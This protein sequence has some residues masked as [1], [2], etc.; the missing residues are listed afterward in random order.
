[1]LLPAFLLLLTTALPAFSQPASQTSTAALDQG[2]RIEREIS[3]GEMHSYTLNVPAGGYAHVDVDQIGISVGISVFADGQKLRGVDASGGGVHEVFSLVAE[4]ATTYR[5][6][7]LA[8]D[9]AAEP[10]KYVIVVDDAHTAT[11]AN[12]AHLEGEKLFE[13]GMDLLYQQTKEARTEAIQKFQQS[14][15]FWQTAKNQSGEARAYYMMGHIYNLL[16]EFAKAEE[17]ATKGLPIAKAAGDKSVE[18][19]LLD[20]IGMSYNERGLRK[21]ALEFYLQAL[22]LRTATDRVGRANTL[23]NIGI[24]YA[25]MSERPKALEYLNEASTILSELGD[26]NW[27]ALCLELTGLMEAKSTLMKSQSL[28]ARHRTPCQQVWLWC[29]KIESARG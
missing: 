6:E 2:K 23:N 8:P 11:E 17:T 14:I 21:K 4:R 9:K 29:L 16:G 20:T 26:R 25:W 19:Y 22:P 12:K 18:A 7:V 15:A 3:G 13:G 24:A 10:G 5:L 27:R 1:M 28:S